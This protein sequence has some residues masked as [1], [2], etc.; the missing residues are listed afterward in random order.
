M[1]D[2]NITATDPRVQHVARVADIDPTAL[3]EFAEAAAEANGDTASDELDV[4]DEAV[5][6]VEGK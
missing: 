3:V 5:S 2:T 1:T 6:L 4:L